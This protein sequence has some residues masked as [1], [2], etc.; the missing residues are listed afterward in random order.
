MCSCT[1]VWFDSLSFLLLSICDDQGFQPS[2]VRSIRQPFACEFMET[3]RRWL[4]KKQKYQTA[5]AF[6]QVK[7]FMPEPICVFKDLVALGLPAVSA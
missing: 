4:T 7:D 5:A 1:D 3:Q 2:E 6:A